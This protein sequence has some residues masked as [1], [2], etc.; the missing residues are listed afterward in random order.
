MKK[1][2]Y[3]IVVL[4]L[5]MSC[6]H[7]TRV[8]GETTQPETIN[9]VRNYVYTN[10][11]GERVMIHNSFPRGDAY[12]APDGKNYFRIIFWT[13]IT[14]QTQHPLAFNLTFPAQFNTG[15]DT[16]SKHDNVYIANDTMTLEKE[17][18][19]NYGFTGVD[20]FL[21]QHLHKPTTLHRTVPPKAST[22]FYIIYLRHST[23]TTP[24]GTLRTGLYLNG[25]NL[26][27]K[28]S[29]YAAQ[30]PHALTSQFEINCGSININDLV[31]A[32]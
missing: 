23:H 15:N 21:N 1:I 26:M 9:T 14:N 19:Y 5:F 20:A 31:P 32:R 17:T 25:Q 3:I 13:R 7:N 29:R 16:T 4:A 28:I 12:T 8:T 18:M 10:A 27:Y 11:A 6:T 2:L 24:D 30:Q 22:G